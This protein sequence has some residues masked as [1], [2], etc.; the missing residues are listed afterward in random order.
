MIAVGDSVA[1]S[2]WCVEQANRHPDVYAAVAVHP[3]EVNGLTDDD[4]AEL[5]AAA[6]RAR[7]TTTGYVGEAALATAGA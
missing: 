1:A 7:L 5:A 6:T 3:T 2:R 4:Y